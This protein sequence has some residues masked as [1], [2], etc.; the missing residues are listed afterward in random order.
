MAAAARAQRS[1]DFASTQDPGVK[2]YWHDPGMR[3]LLYTTDNPDATQHEFPIRPSVG[4]IGEGFVLDRLKKLGYDASWTPPGTRSVDIRVSLPSAFDVQVKTATGPRWLVAGEKGVQVS[5]NLWFALVEWD[6]DLNRASRTL[7]MSS[8]DARAIA[9]EQRD[10]W[11]QHVGPEKKARGFYIV[12]RVWA[13]AEPRDLSPYE[14]AWAS[15]PSLS[16]TSV[17]RK[18]TSRE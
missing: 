2:K 11:R 3:T 10:Q 9:H 6:G 4:E 5:E 16:T 13:A 12:E 18:S 15:L 17:A 14:D 8:A 7:V 1:R